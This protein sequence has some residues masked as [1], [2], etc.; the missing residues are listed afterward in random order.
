LKGLV[1]MLKEIALTPEVFNPNSYSNEDNLLSHMRTMGSR[2]L[3]YSGANPFMLSNLYD[4][5]LRQEIIKTVQAIEPPIKYT[6]QNMCEKLAPLFVTRPP[7]G[8]WPD[9]DENWA[10]E[11]INS[12]QNN[13]KKINRIVAC[14]ETAK[15]L[16]T[17]GYKLSGV[18]ETQDE[19]FWQDMY[20]HDHIPMII[21]EQIS[22]LRLICLHA[23]FIA[24]SSAY[25]KGTDTDET[26]FVL[27]LIKKTVYL[28]YNSIVLFHVHAEG[29]DIHEAG[30]DY[31]NR[32]NHLTTNIKQKLLEVSND[33]AK[34]ILY[35]WP[36]LRERILLAGIST[37]RDGKLVPNARW[38]IHLGHIARPNEKSTSD[39]TEWKI[40]GKCGLM[41][42]HRYFYSDGLAPLVI[43]EI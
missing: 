41:D 23:G 42:W 14:E 24:V 37:T 20:S 27:E 12:S 33:K 28:N 34:I 11:A 31:E 16:R 21:Q 26:E 29:P 22:S 1:R 15:S 10:L 2:L 18:F 39:Y 36:K 9:S 3:F 32:L 4:G 35:V 30:P 19:V 17:Q 25:I 13:D 40:L 38:G 43:I 7:M 6:I 5:S 8:N